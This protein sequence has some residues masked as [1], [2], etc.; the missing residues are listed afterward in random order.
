[1]PIHD[2]TR[3]DAGVFHHFHLSWIAEI[4]RSLNK[5][6]LPRE[7]YAL[8]ERVTRDFGPL[9]LSP[10]RPIEGSLSDEP[11]PSGGMTVF[12]DPP[13]VRFHVRAERDLY[14]AKVNRIG[15][16]HQSGH[17]LVAIIE[18]VPPGTKDHRVPFAAFIR[19]AEQALLAGIH[20]LIVDLF[21]PTA[22][23]PDGIHRV[24]WGG[25]GDGDFALPEDTPLTCVSYV[26]HPGVDV[27]LEPRAVGDRLTDM[28]LFL[29]QQVY[30]PVPLEVTYLAAWEAVPR[31]LQKTIG[32]HANERPSPI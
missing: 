27:Y 13:R 4:K 29:A 15:I 26:G 24:I 25:E 30:V 2:W 17:Q 19:R 21:P 31:F 16:R 28:P 14:A 6:L 18:I 3:A 20:L 22:R 9:V 23:D 11:E 7:Y 5:V 10:E 8:I 1:M 32:P 12:D